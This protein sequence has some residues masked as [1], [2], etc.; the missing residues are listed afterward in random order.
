MK[1]NVHNISVWLKDKFTHKVGVQ[2]YRFRTANIYRGREF[3][4][5]LVRLDHFVEGERSRYVHG[6]LIPVYSH[7][8]YA[9]GNDGLVHCFDGLYGLK[10]FITNKDMSYAQAKHRFICDIMEKTLWPY[11]LDI[12]SEVMLQ[13]K[14]IE[15][16]E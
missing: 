1:E 12:L 5:F 7:V 6:I 10:K 15:T 16:G 4:S 14:A 2:E 8:L 13:L 3:S 9:V 11:N